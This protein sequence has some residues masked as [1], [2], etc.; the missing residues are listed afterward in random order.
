[1][2]D[3]RGKSD[4]PLT[5]AQLAE[6]RAEL[7]REL[8]RLERGME[9]RDE[10]K[11]VELDQTS[12]GRLSRIDALQNQQITAGLRGREIARH[13]DLIAALERMERGSFGRC[14]RCEGAIPHGRLLVI[15][16]ARNCAGC[17]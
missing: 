12:V 8:A 9:R 4:D 3:Q 5:P 11:T 6:L 1:M 2:P 15:P 13:G 10:T 14:E 7:E 16:E 17:G